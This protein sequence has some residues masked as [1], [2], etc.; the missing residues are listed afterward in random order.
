MSFKKIICLF[1][2]LLLVLSFAGCGKKDGANGDTTRKSDN[3]TKKAEPTTVVTANEKTYELRT[4]KGENGTKTIT[5]YT[6]GEKEQEKIRSL[7]Y[8][9]N[10]SKND[11]T[12]FVEITDYT[13]GNFVMY[14]NNNVKKEATDKISESIYYSMLFAGLDGTVTEK[15]ATEKVIAVVGEG[16][17]ESVFCEGFEILDGTLYYIFF[18]EKHDQTPAYYRVNVTTGEVKLKTAPG[19]LI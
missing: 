16:E 9:L 12:N 13:N 5:V 19:V 14:R 4:V 6:Y 2:T 1:M 8:G 7:E 11:G 18:I 15:Q 10:T 17:R 3:T